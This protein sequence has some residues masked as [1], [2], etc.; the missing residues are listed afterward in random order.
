MEPKNFRFFQYIKSIFSNFVPGKEII[1]ERRAAAATFAAARSD[2]KE[3][4][5][6]VVVDQPLAKQR[7][8]SRLLSQPSVGSRLT[9]FSNLFFKKENFSGSSSS[10]FAGGIFFLFVGFVIGNLFGTFLPAIR[11]F[12]SW[13]GFIVIFLL[14]F[15]EFI[16]YIRYQRKNRFFLILWN[17]PR[18]CF[19][20]EPVPLDSE[21]EKSKP[22][23]LNNEVTAA[24]KGKQNDNKIAFTRNFP[25]FINFS[26]LLSPTQRSSRAASLARSVNLLGRPAPLFSTERTTTFFERSPGKETFPAKGLPYRSFNYFKIGFLLGFFIDAYKVGS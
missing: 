7:V 9:V 24:K 16:S 4:G 25:F 1:A 15:I 23:P 14:F 6:K 10:A 17:L 22:P 8:D 26:G 12:F 2:R 21:D 11:I 5:N 3:T 13:D 19:D 20:E 18:G